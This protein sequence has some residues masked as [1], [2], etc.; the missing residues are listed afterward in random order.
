MYPDCE[1]HYTDWMSSSE[2]LGPFCEKKLI[3][4]H[5]TPVKMQVKEWYSMNLDLLGRFLQ[6][7]SLWN[8]NNLWFIAR[9]HEQTPFN[10]KAK[11][12]NTLTNL[13]LY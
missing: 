1:T 10:N 4:Q 12:D 11:E 2:I 13:A 8:C 7:L 5:E 3:N 9:F 6:I